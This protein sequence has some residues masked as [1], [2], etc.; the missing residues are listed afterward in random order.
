MPVNRHNLNNV[1]QSAWTKALK[2]MP[3][4]PKERSEKWVDSLAACFKE[5]YKG[6]RHR[7]FWR[8]NKEN[9]DDFK[10]N[11]FLFDLVVCSV[12]TTESLQRQSNPLK[13]IAECHWQIE[14]E[15]NKANSRDIIVDMSKLVM[16]SAENKL[17]IASHR[18]EETEKGILEQCSEIAG[19][20][21][22]NIYFC[23]VSHPEEWHNDP[24]H[25]SLHEWTAGDCEPMGSTETG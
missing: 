13:F 8:S 20:C 14:S 24:K 25:P 12:S 23:F 17:F 6:D 18:E 7:V 3:H 22:G 11:E 5:N 15:F 21:S 4:A 9:Y 1:I 19:R 10:L 2:D 16:G